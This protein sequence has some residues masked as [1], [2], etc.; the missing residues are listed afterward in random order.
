MGLSGEEEYRLINEYQ[1]IKY[2]IV[3]TKDPDLEISLKKIKCDLNRQDFYGFDR[4]PKFIND[5]VYVLFVE[6]MEARMDGYDVNTKYWDW[7]EISPDRWDLSRKFENVRII[8]KTNKG[9]IKVT[10]KDLEKYDLENTI[11]KMNI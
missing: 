2:W 8:S 1:D 6:S 9:Q 10:K 11:S 3:S 7:L 5:Y 4:R